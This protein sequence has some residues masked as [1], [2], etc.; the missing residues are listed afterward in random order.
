MEDGVFEVKATSGDT[1]LGGEDFDTLL[2]E[3]C[4]QEFNKK[5]K[6]DISSNK[7]AVRRLRTACEKAKIT[8]S[9]STSA[10]VEIDS[11]FE[12]IDMS[13]VI[14]RAKFENLCEPLFKK[15]LKPVEQ[16]LQDSGMSKADVHDIVLV[17]GSTRIPRVQ[18]L[19]S[20][21]FNGKELCKSI[22][23]DEAVAYGAAVQASILAG[24]SDEK[25]DKLLLLDVTPLSLGLETAGGVMTKLIPRNSTI[26]GKKSQVFSTYAD[27]Q[28]GVLIQV[29]EG[30][31]PLTKD[32]N[33]L[34]KFELTGI[35]PA[36][37]GVPQIEV[38]F[39][40]DANG[41]LNVTAKDKASNK[42]S[43]ITIKNDKGRLSN[44]DIER[45]VR[46]AEKFKEEDEA[47]VKRI[48][49]RN[50]LENY[51]YQ[52]KNSVNEEAVKTKLGD[53]TGEVE[54]LVDEGMSWLDDNKN[55]TI[56]EINDKKSDLESKIAPIMSSL[57][58]DSSPSGKTSSDKAEQ[59]TSSGP[60]V[61]EVD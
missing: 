24:N 43:N 33:L 25:L 22:N 9:A 28:P 52:V 56:D 41:I 20:S 5:N 38:I 6:C 30:E 8:L 1:H 60:T 50:G 58:Q 12:G 27:N 42:A 61:E 47:V 48:E 54:K 3:Y 34:G 11:L 44:D 59:H 29:Y 36:P 31:R 4:I 7:K 16:V 49:A 15:C 40:I 37:R 17:G 39:D 19:L 26:P 46:D 51:L 55:A 53:K 32:N 35:A 14:T 10:T 18:Q 23:P 21:F 45:M 13:L 57:Y 2:V